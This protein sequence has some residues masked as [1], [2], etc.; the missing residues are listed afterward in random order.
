MS[1]GAAVSA[2]LTIGGPILAAVLTIWLEK[3]Q[4][5]RTHATMEET[6]TYIKQ[7]LDGDPAGLINLSRQL[8]RMRREAARKRR[9]S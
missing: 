9:P 3:R 6:D 2:F 5:E 4:Q 8:E 7:H 1:I